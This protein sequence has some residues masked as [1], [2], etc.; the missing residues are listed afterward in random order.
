VER[1]RADAGHASLSPEAMACGQRCAFALVEREI[2]SAEEIM[3]ERAPAPLRVRV[4]VRE[5]R[6]Y[7]PGRVAYVS[8]VQLEPCSAA[9]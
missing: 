9:E 7:V 1:A 2:A 6:V 5:D 8:V 4:R 3:R